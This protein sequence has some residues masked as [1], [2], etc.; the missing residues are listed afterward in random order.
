MRLVLDDFSA[1]I[2]GYISHSYGIVLEI[3]NVSRNEV[4]PKNFGHYD[5]IFAHNMG[6][7]LAIALLCFFYRAFGAMLALGW[8]AC[9]WSF[10]LT[11][12]VTRALETSEQSPLSFVLIA[13]SAIT[14]HLIVEG[15]GYI[16][17]SVAAIFLSK[18]IMKYAT[19]DPVF[20]SIMRSC[21]RITLAAVQGEG[22]ARTRR[23]IIGMR[24]KDKYPPRQGYTPD[25]RHGGDREAVVGR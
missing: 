15:F 10:V 4:L 9:T 7:L 11:V 20:K 18:A 23:F 22:P 24:R 14:P 16:V 21:A 8:N 12:L 2:N 6:V 19:N 25:L 1:R 17:G 5:V 13:F 3:A